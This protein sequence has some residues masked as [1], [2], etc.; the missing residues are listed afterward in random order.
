FGLINKEFFPASIQELSAYASI[1]VMLH[2]LEHRLNKLVNYCSEFKVKN[3][4][5]RRKCD[6]LYQENNLIFTNNTPNTSP[7]KCQEHKLT[8][9]D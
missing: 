4:K 2:S 8:N 5:L 1:H 7:R 6:D 9:D 3:A